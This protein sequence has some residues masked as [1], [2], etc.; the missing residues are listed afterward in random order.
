MKERINILLAKNKFAK[1][2]TP[3]HLPLIGTFHSISAQILR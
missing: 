2:G 1:P 3:A